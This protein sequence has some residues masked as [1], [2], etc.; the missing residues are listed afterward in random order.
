[1]ILIW[2]D[3]LPERRKQTQ[4]ICNLKCKRRF[5]LPSSIQQVFQIKFKMLK[6]SRTIFAHLSGCIFHTT[7]LDPLPPAE[8]GQIIGFFSSTAV[9][10]S[11]G[12][13]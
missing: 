12:D 7:F 1:M 9:K 6:G 4:S 3:N 13:V 5:K 11:R 2:Q 8:C 10:R